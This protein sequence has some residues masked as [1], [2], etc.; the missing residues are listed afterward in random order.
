MKIGKL[1][2]LTPVVSDWEATDHWDDDVFSVQRA[3]NALLS[4]S[5]TRASVSAS[6]P[7]PG[8]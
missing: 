5:F 3:R 7:S 8:M 4:A 1:F 6:I 2:H